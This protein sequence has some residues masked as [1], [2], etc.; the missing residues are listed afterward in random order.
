MDNYLPT[1]Q[2]I[3]EMSDEKLL[4]FLNTLTVEKIDLE[5]TQILFTIFQYRYTILQ[6]HGSLIDGVHLNN[7]L[8]SIRI[9]YKKHLGLN[10]EVTSLLFGFEDSEDDEIPNSSNFE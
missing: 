10:I 5:L 2:E 1:E 9:E 3:K 8:F 7:D 4:E 6:K